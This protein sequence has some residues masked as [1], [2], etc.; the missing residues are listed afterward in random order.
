M[1]TELDKIYVVTH[2]VDMSLILK[3]TLSH[4]VLLSLR[5]IPIFYNQFWDLWVQFQRNLLKRT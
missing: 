4:A 5:F 1:L 3:S 2:F